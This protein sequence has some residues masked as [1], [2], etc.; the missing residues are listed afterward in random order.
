M[1]KKK[2][3]KN[4][5]LVF[6]D[7]DNLYINFGPSSSIIEELNKTLRQIAK[8]VGEIT[9]VFIFAP[10]PSILPFGELFYKAGFFTIVCSKTKS[11]DG[12]DK[13]TTDE[14]IIKLGGKLLAEMSDLTHFVLGS[15]DKDFNQFLLKEVSRRGLDIA[16]IVSDRRSLSSEIARMIDKEPNGKE[17]MLYILSSKKEGE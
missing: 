12:Q 13:D 9:N 10:Y 11:K 1:G 6:L 4:K 16:I 17:K 8:E 3:K 14:T 15:G 2:G 5:V 7:F